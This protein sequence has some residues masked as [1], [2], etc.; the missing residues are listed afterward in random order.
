[1]TRRASLAAALLTLA[2]LAAG[3]LCAAD[4][5]TLVDTAGDVVRRVVQTLVALGVLIVMA[6]PSTAESE[7]APP[8]EHDDDAASASRSLRSGRFAAPSGSRVG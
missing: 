8:A 6:R 1:M 7:P 4:G 2:T 3:P 5:S